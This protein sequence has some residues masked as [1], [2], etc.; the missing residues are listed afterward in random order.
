MDGQLRRKD[1]LMKP[2]FVSSADLFQNHRPLIV[3]EERVHNGN[4]YNAVIYHYFAVGP[5]LSLTRVLARETRLL[6]LNPQD[7]LFVRELTQLSP[8]RLRL[9]TLNVAHDGSSKRTDLGYVLLESSGPDA[10]FRVVERHAKA[11]RKF[12]CLVTCMDEPPSDDVFLREGTTA[13]SDGN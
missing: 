7:G 9:D 5:N 2:P 12:D 4:M 11:P 3:F 13:K 10:P 1:E 8:S 6:A